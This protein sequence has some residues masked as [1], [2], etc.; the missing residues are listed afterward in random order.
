MVEKAYE[1]LGKK[2]DTEK[3]MKEAETEDYCIKD[4]TCFDTMDEE[5]RAKAEAFAREYAAFLDLSKTERE[6]TAEAVRM[7]EAAGFVPYSFGKKVK[8]GEKYY[9]NNR[10]KS[11][12]LFIIGK[13]PLEDGVR[14][15]AAHIDSPRLDLKPHPLYE[16][17]GLGYCKTRYYGGIKKYQWTTVP[18]ALHGTV[19]LED[20]RAV[21]IRIGESDEDPIFYISDLLP[22]LDREQGAKP[23]SK[24][25]PA[26][27]LNVLM[28]AVP[29]PSKAGKADKAA[30]AVKK[31][32]M[33]LL[34]E[35]YGMTEDDFFS[36]E[37]SFVPAMKAREIGL[38]RSLLGAYGHDDRVCAYPVL[39]SVLDTV[40][41]PENTIYAILADKEETGSDGVTGM[42][43]D[44]MFDILENLSL[45]LG[46]NPAGVR[47]HSK[48]LSA[49]VNAAYDPIYADVFDP[50]NSSYLNR[51][52]VV[53][54]YTGGAGKGGTSDASAEF[55]AFVR[56]ALAGGGVLWQTGELGKVEAGGG[57]TVAKYIANRN[58]DTIDIGVPVLSMHAPYEVV[59]KYDVYQMYLAAGAF[60]RFSEV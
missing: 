23:L 3:R 43:C 39:R 27:N 20:G 53:T 18:L 8:P 16:E 50:R 35:R 48:C 6:A 19:V 36:A 40:G 59:S 51:G 32:L 11:V 21:D 54:K 14:I 30:N 12:H 24:A 17:S 5:M 9:F 34:N 45:T 60:Y 15:C 58:I 37:L 28:G 47:M 13:R 41:T 57:G 22:H 55:V 31:N 7:A 26:E 1:A 42:Q 25:I 56:R 52:V 46:A 44:L 4:V 29:A 33:R 10:G 2:E 49:D 38:D